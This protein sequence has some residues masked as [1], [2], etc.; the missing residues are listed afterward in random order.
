MRSIF[1]EVMSQLGKKILSGS[2]NLTT[3]SFPIKAMIPASLL[4]RFGA[5]TMH[6]SYYLPIAA[7]SKDNLE[8]LKWVITST[9]GSYMRNIQFYKPVS[10]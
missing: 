5:S 8:R 10:Y 6:F 1:T 9:I 3:I 4:E 2:F 7:E